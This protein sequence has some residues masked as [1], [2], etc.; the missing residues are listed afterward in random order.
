MV[1]YS[2]DIR[3]YI[4]YGHLVNTPGKL[5]P[6]SF[7]MLRKYSLIVEIHQRYPSLGQT[8]TFACFLFIGYFRQYVFKILHA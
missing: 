5:Y 4:Q 1:K 7:A 2:I 6:F 3:V 8:Y